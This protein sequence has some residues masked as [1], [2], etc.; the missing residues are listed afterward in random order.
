MKK[1]SFGTKCREKLVQGVEALRPLVTSLYGPKKKIVVSYVGGKPVVSNYFTGLLDTF[2]IPDDF[3]DVGVQIARDVVN[4]IRKTTGSGAGIACVQAL[5][6]LKEGHKQLTAGIPF[7]DV[8][9]A[10]TLMSDNFAAFLKDRSAAIAASMPGKEKELYTG[11]ALTATGDRS[12]S[13]TMADMFMHVGATGNID[14]RRSEAT[15]LRVEYV[16]GFSFKTGALSYKFIPRGTKKL[17]YDNPL[18]LVT[19]RNLARHEDLLD[20]LIHCN[21]EGRPLIIICD[22]MSNDVLELLLH[23]I[24]EGAL[25]AIALRTPEYDSERYDALM[26]IATIT[27]G[28]MVPKADV[29]AKTTPAVLGTAT[30]AIVVGDTC[31]LI[32]DAKNLPDTY[33]AAVE[34]RIEDEKK[35][36]AKKKLKERL[37]SLKGKSAILFVGGSSEVDREA[38]YYKVE[39]AAHAVRGAMH[40]GYVPGGC[41]VFFDYASQETSPLIPKPLLEAFYAPFTALVPDEMARRPL[42][43]FVAS[44]ISS[45]YSY[46]HGK[47]VPMLESLVID[48]AVVLETS[49]ASSL[50]IVKTVLSAGAIVR[51]V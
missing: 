21:K 15:G 32:Y 46:T 5:A 6:L 29:L 11:V 23:N 31:T 26:D 19:E 39:C 17:E 18:V 42:S 20:I 51:T 13:D 30:K 49:A 14:L 28:T 34:K 8:V 47:P 40:S 38:N 35:Q 12:I 24:K 45:G 41:Q 43:E 7:K 16:D 2:T 48:P 3:S 37:G 36:L 25:K 33:V 44:D 22:G 27:A 50:S 1:I 9:R 10:M 4:Q